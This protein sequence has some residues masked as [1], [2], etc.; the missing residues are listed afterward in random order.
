MLALSGVHG[1]GDE[2]GLEDTP[3]LTNASDPVGVAGL[4]D[5]SDLAVWYVVP[6]SSG[7]PDILD[8]FSAGLPAILLCVREGAVEQRDGWI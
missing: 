2:S 4:V 7:K 8:E 1:L 5:V 6:N 3:G